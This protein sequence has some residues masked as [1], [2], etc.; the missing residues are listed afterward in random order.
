MAPPDKKQPPPKTPSP[1]PAGEEKLELTVERLEA[2]VEEL[3]SGEADLE[4]SI[5][6]FQEGRKLGAQAMKK[7][8]A[9]DRR[10]QIVISADDDQL[11]TE[12]FER[13][14]S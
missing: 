13:D 12:D 11:H 2:I 1:A 14:E 10:V 3:E 8:D 7:L 5:A 9:L 6:L 4:R